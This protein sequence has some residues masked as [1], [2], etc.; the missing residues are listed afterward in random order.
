MNTALGTLRRARAGMIAEKRREGVLSLRQEMSAAFTRKRGSGGVKKPSKGSSRAVWKHRFVCLAYYGQTKVPTTEHE[1]SELFE[2]G[3]G[4]KEVKFNEVDISAAQF[5]DILHSA[6]PKLANSG[7]FQLYKCAPNSRELELLSKLAHASPA[8]LKQLVNNA[9]TYIVPL[10]SDLDL[11]PILDAPSEV[12]LTYVFM[13]WLP[14]CMC[15]CMCVCVCVH[16]R[17]CVCA[18]VCCVCARVCVLCVCVCAHVCVCVHVYMRLCMYVC[19]CVCAHVCVG[20]MS[21]LCILYNANMFDT[22]VNMVLLLFIRLRK[23]AC[24][25][26]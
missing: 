18:C 4:E 21:H 25:V 6:F 15:V 26:V 19:V 14:V 13:V 20:V 10:Q 23:P 16:A 12:S 24:P 22:K 17:A 9:R 5:R 7:G 3:L 1:K 8:N 11:S 2:A